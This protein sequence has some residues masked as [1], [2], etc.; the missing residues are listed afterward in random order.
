MVSVVI[1]QAGGDGVTNAAAKDQCSQKFFGRI[2]HRTRSQQKRN[3]WK[4]WRQQRG[5]CDSEKSPALK[6]PGNLL[7][8]YP[9][10][11]AFHGLFAALARQSIS[12]VAANH[13]AQRCH[14]CIV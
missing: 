4:W 8:P 14:D 9:G 5:N 11:L 10:E 12:N 3:E 7:R 13:R 1:A 2:L 6:C